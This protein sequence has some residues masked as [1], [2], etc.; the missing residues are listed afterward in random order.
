M[1]IKKFPKA[2]LRFVYFPQLLSG[3][4]VDKKNEETVNCFGLR[5]E[6]DPRK[7]VKN[8]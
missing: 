5:S 6:R 3:C 7:A 2:D 8:I 1:K 4:T